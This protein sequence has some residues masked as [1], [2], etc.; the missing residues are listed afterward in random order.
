MPLKKEKKKVRHK[1]DLFVTYSKKS[2]EGVFKR[3]Q[4]RIMKLKKLN[5]D[6]SK[7]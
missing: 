4:K 2:I 5:K 7:N 3:L 1:K 6:Y